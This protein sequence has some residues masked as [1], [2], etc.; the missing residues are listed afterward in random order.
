M[1]SHNYAPI[2]TKSFPQFIWVFRP[3]PKGSRS[4]R[5]RVRF[6]LARRL[7]SISKRIK[8]NEDDSI[9]IDTSPF[10]SANFFRWISHVTINKN[11]NLAEIKGL[12]QNYNKLNINIFCHT[13]QFNH[14]A[15]LLDKLNIDCTN[16]I[17]FVGRGNCFFVPNEIYQLA[18]KFKYVYVQHLLG[19]LDYSLNLRPLPTG[20]STQ[21]VSPSVINFMKKVNLVDWK[22]SISK[23]VKILLN[24]DTSNNT[25]ERLKC[26]RTL[27]HHPNS[28][29]I[30]RESFSSIFEKMTKI[31]FVASPP[32]A[33][34]DC[35]RTWEAI[36]A[37]AV[38]IVL[39]H[40]FP[41]YRK[42]YPVWV[43]HDW[44]ELLHYDEEQL[45]S[46]YIEIMNS[47]IEIPCVKDFEFY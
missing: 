29:I 25:K 4:V 16:W 40:S 34:P 17:L 46:K 14:L 36:Y 10:I 42:N 15:N 35:Y 39:K 33:G 13:D 11:S 20:I 19:P 24:F 1:I 3:L 7:P 21:E 27:Q 41:E 18:S 8:R 44:S 45:R 22:E 31:M 28:Y 43:I 6:A 23:E 37:G 38:P 30:G 32:G 26:F 9:K 47:N 2:P 5:E 12:L